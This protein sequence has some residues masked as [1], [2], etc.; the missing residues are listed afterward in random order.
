MLVALLAQPDRTLA[1][2]SLRHAGRKKT[3]DYAVPLDAA[4]KSRMVPHLRV[5]PGN[6]LSIYGLTG[7]I[8]K[9]KPEGRACAHHNA[10]SSDSS[11]D[12]L[13]G[14]AP[15]DEITGLSFRQY[16]GLL[17]VDQGLVPPVA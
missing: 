8:V 12:D 7:L 11:F 6:G 16:A 17:V 3:N 13:I 2:P 10:V 5:C 1:Q 14:G 15:Y 4:L 9:R